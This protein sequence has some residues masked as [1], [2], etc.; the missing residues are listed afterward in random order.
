[1]IVY[2]KMVGALRQLRTQQDLKPAL[3]Q[4]SASLTE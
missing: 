3:G 2:S 1:M 4:L